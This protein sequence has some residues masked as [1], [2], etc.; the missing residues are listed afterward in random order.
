MG[1]SEWAQEA[2]VGP[3]ESRG[4]K[5]E[6]GRKKRPKKWD[7]NGG[8]KEESKKKKEKVRDFFYTKANSQ[9]NGYADWKRERKEVGRN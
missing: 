8:T 9:N 4:R 2:H 6:E 3:K 7:R 1:S 5:R